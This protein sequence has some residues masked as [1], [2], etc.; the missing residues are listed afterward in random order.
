MAAIKAA[1]LG[2]NVTCIEGRGRLGGTCLNVGCIPSK[3]LLKSSEIFDEAKNHA[4]SH[5]VMVKDV[6]IDLPKMM[7]QKDKAVDGLTKGIE[8]LFKKNK[9]EYK[10]GWGK[11][12]SGS[13]VEVQ[14]ADGGS[15]T[16]KAKNI[17]IA[18][19]SEVSPLKG[20]D[21][22]EERIVSST[23]ALVL[24]EIP[25]SLIV[26][27]GG[28]IGLEMGSVWARLGAKV[29][30]V[31]FL[32]K[33]VPAMDGEVRKAFQ[34]A[35]TK[36]GFK[37]KLGVKVNSAKVEGNTVVLDTEL[38]KDGKKEE[39]KADIVLVSAGR[40]PFLGHGLGL[41][42]VGIELDERGRI[43][44]DQHFKVK[45]SEGNIFA[46][47]DVIPGPMLAHKAEE[48][49]VACVE[50]LNGKGGH[51]NYNTVPGIVYTHPEVASV[52]L[53]EEMA[54]EKGLKF[55]TGKFPFAAN[56]RA[57]TV[58]DAEGLVKFVADAETD[59]ILGAHI[60]GPSA[61]ELIQEC[62]MGME[63]GASS[64]DIARTCHGHPT[65]SEAVKEAA[66]ATCAQA[67]HA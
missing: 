23:G 33:I 58:D 15:E 11:L 13:E 62:V 22:D 65:F 25:K 28:Y 40:R 67:I 35:L 39:M 18:T 52:G 21:I 7:E 42:T 32:D 4:A 56:S 30:V 34:R 61:G 45:S 64:E 50:L 19:G 60:M 41:D 5:G 48:D 66:L 59:K 37:F 14:L 1:Q 8:F 27:G 51:V 6:S 55:K 49:G 9:V 3:A 29:T 36:Q 47:G 20:I 57:K 24:K 17:I 16:V 54:K 12:K 2:M 38:V 10:K 46:I 31:E 53:T 44:V 26:I 63:Y 43:P